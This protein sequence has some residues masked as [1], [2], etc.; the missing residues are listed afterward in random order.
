MDKADSMRDSRG[1][2]LDAAAYERHVRAVEEATEAN[3]PLHLIEKATRE[4]ERREARA[5]S[6][7]RQEK[8]RQGR[9]FWKER[10]RER[11]RER[12]RGGNR[13][14]WRDRGRDRARPSDPQESERVA[15]ATRLV[16][17]EDDIVVSWG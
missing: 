5:R 4:A 8:Q 16:S 15:V 6:E 9:E 17:Q 14:F 2:A 1:N 3:D 12:E 10:A 11:E 13:G 7:E